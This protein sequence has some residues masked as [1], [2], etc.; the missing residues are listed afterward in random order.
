MHLLSEGSN[1]ATPAG[2]SHADGINPKRQRVNANVRPVLKGSENV[3]TVER[4][5]VHADATTGKSHASFNRSQHL[6]VKRNVM[7]LQR[8]GMMT[9]AMHEGELSYR[10]SQNPPMT[11]HPVTWLL[12]VPISCLS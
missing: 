12:A 3:Q 9:E 10:E 2:L 1:D 4:G 5:S 7:H 6:P 11:H 8:Q